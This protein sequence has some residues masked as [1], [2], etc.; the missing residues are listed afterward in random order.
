MALAEDPPTPGGTDLAIT[1]F[2]DSV[3]DLTDRETGRC[4]FPA[5][6]LVPARET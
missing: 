6:S 1:A 5:F 2:A 4:S 3:R